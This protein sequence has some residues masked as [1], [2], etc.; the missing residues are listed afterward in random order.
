MPA[1]WPSRVAV[2][3]PRLP[4]APWSLFLAMA[5]VVA[6][7]DA[8][9]YTPQPEP[10]PD[11]DPAPVEPTDCQAAEDNLRDL[12]C[13]APEGFLLADG[14]ADACERNALDGVNWHP[15]CLAAIDDCSRVDAAWKG[16]DCQ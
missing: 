16:V 2:A 12:G 15:V 8:C 14:F 5:L 11:P 4:R 1:L 6:G 10:T 3:G 9:T 7:C 13:R